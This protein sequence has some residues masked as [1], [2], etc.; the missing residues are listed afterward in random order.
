MKTFGPHISMGFEPPFE[1]TIEIL[2]NNQ[3]TGAKRSV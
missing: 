2:V 1:T 3:V